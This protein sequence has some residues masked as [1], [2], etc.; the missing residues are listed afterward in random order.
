MTFIVLSFCEE[1][2]EKKELL[3]KLGLIEETLH[4]EHFELL[5]RLFLRHSIN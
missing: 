1:E 3:I 2:E 5:Q 4:K